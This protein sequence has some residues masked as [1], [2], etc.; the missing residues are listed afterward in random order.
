[1]P[2]F[3][4][5]P[6]TERNPPAASPAAAPAPREDFLG[7][8]QAVL[9]PREVA[10][11]PFKLRGPVRPGGRGTMTLELLLDAGDAP[12]PV[13]LSAGELVGPAMG[14]IPASLV[15]VTPAAFTL[16]PGAATPVEVTVEVP[17]D[18]LPGRYAG[19]ITLNGAESRI[20]PIEADVG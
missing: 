4:R 10:E 9:T 3:T 5:R 14:V 6:Y 1:M 12:A 17:R 7:L 13:R 16:A 18:A 8:A 20:L 19:A 15:R 2:Y 11:A